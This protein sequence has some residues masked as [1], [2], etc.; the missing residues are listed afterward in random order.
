MRWL[1]PE[2][3]ALFGENMTAIHSIE[4][5]HLASHLYLF[6]AWDTCA[7]AWLSWQEVAEL[8]ELCSLPIAPV[9]HIGG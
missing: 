8:A 4:Y 5:G 9:L 2:H 3:I 6:A 1:V 7:Q